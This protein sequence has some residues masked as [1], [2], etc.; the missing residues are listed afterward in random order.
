[1]QH[2][3]RFRFID[4]LECVVVSAAYLRSAD[5]LGSTEWN[6]VVWIGRLFTCVRADAVHRCATAP[7]QRV[8]MPCQHTRF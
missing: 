6:A 1:M 8:G 2:I 4:D 5:Q 7:V 3:T